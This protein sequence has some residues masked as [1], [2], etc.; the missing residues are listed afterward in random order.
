MGPMMVSDALFELLDH[1]TEYLLL[2][3]QQVGGCRGLPYKPGGA[4]GGG[5]SWRC[6]LLAHGA[7]Y[8]LWQQQQADA[9]APGG[10]GD[11]ASEVRW[12][13]A[14]GGGGGGGPPGWGGQARVGDVFTLVKGESKGWGVWVVAACLWWWW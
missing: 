3:Q 9:Q 11:P 7:G 5:G 8:L 1:R 10:Q 4:G 13:R 14:R 12:G 6:W 2:L